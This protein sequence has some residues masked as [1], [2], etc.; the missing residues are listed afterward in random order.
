MKIIK[1]ISYLIITLS[2]LILPLVTL[3]QTGDETSIAHDE[4]VG[5]LKKVG[6]NSGYNLEVTPPEIIGFII[7]A[8]IDFLGL[9]FIILAIVAGYGWMTAGGNEEK[10][11]K[12]QTTLKEAIIGL[13]I[14]ISVWTLWNF[15]FQSLIMK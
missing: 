6:N 11:K 12:A 7:G 1:K 3:A 5:K 10:V 9:A 15:V 14:S 4:M 13:V 8:F 2:I